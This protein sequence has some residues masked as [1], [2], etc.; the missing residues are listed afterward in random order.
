MENHTSRISR[1]LPSSAKS[2][3]WLIPQSFLSGKFNPLEI[4]PNLSSANFNPR[5]KSGKIYVKW[6]WT[7]KSRQNLYLWFLLF[8]F[9]KKK[10]KKSEAVQH[11]KVLLCRWRGMI[12]HAFCA[13][14]F[15]QL[16][17]CPQITIPATFRETGYPR[18]QICSKN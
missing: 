13:H 17:L 5:E 3:P 4:P 9:S 14:F 8:S 16:I 2:K 1:N 18:N 12:Q 6:K 7:A 11:V 15:S 10:K